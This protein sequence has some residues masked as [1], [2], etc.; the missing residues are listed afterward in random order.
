[1]P[2]S[3]CGTLGSTRVGRRW[4]RGLGHPGLACR[5]LDLI[6]E[7]SVCPRPLCQGPRRPREV[8]PV[9][10]QPERKLGLL[11]VSYRREA[12][13]QHGPDSWDL[14]CGL[15]GAHWVSVGAVSWGQR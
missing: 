6:P 9:A 8:G 3:G 7:P 4:L 10:G 1:M 12:R 13:G 14:Q 11:G 5:E 15:L 2:P